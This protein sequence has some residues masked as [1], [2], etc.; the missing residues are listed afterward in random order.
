[1]RCL[2]YALGAVVALPL[3]TGCPAARLVPNP[4]N[5][6]FGTVL[7]GADQRRQPGGYWE[8]RGDREARITG[9]IIADAQAGSFAAEPTLMRARVG[10]GQRSPGIQE[11]T[12]TPGSVGHHFATLAPVI[13]GGGDQV[14][15]MTLSGDGAYI[16]NEGGLQVVD[17]AA[18]VVLPDADKPLD[19][20]RI[21]YTTSVTCTFNVRNGTQAPLAVLVGIMPGSVGSAFRVT[22]PTTPPASAI[23]P[24]ATLAISVTFTPPPM[25]AS[26]WMFMVGILVFNQAAQAQAGRTACGVGF[27]QQ[28][29][30]PTPPPSP[31]PALLTCP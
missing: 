1:M 3:L 15:K 28:E 30:P 25:P 23:A 2:G 6:D 9:L 8:N 17:G 27:G 29:A 22:A 11:L 14:T 7:V 18:G 13:A 31:A 24:N 12:F 26:E 19:C 4:A 20:G 5:H 16:V 10:P 21:A